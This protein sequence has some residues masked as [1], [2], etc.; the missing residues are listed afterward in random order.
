MTTHLVEQICV[1]DRE[2]NADVGSIGFDPLRQC[3]DTASSLLVQRETCNVNVGDGDGGDRV[4]V[5]EAAVWST[6]RMKLGIR[7]GGTGRSIGNDNSSGFRSRNCGYP[8]WL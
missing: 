6:C 4:V 2:V 3:L 5:V 1:G 8:L 7:G